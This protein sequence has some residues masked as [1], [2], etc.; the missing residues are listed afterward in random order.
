MLE[1]ERDCQNR[2][3][4][5]FVWDH[6]AWVLEQRREYRQ[7]AAILTMSAD[8]VRGMPLDHSQPSTEGQ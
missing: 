1:H 6:A 2:K 3:E 4:R 8:P 5:P 7:G